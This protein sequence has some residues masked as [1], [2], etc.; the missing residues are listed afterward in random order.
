MGTADTLGEAGKAVVAVVVDEDGDDGMGVDQLVVVGAAV[1]VTT[2]LV[3]RAGRADKV[4][5]VV[6][7][8]VVV[9]SGKAVRVTL[10]PAAPPSTENSRPYN[11]PQMTNQRT[12]TP[13]I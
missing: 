2:G 5:I 12:S 6:V 7:T 9:D 10:F 3:L 1:Q 4:V 13:S 8:A 11:Q